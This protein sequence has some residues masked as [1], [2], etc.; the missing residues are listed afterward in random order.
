MA[1]ISFVADEGEEVIVK[2]SV[3]AVSTAGAT[4][5]LQELNGMTFDRLKEK[6]ESLREK[7]LSK[8]KIEAKP[9]VKEAFYTAAYRAALH[10]FILQD[11]DGCYRGLVKNIE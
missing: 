9:E 10:P 8:N 3:S 4:L 6:R 7:E 1:C 2:T 11:A 5:N